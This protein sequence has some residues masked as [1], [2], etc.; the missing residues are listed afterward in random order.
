MTQYNFRMLFGN[1][2]FM[3]F[4]FW[5]KMSDLCEE[6]FE[7]GHQYK[8]IFQ[9]QTMEENEPLI[10]SIKP[11]VTNLMMRYNTSCQENSIY[12]MNIFSFVI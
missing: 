2:Y 6:H 11:N 1:I 12:F 3:V 10:A 4:L 5:K 7:S 8:C 9:W